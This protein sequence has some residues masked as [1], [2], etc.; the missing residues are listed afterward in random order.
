LELI[1]VRHGETEWT[2]SGRYTGITEIS[3]TTGGEREAT[4]V[5][6]ILRTLLGG[7]EPVVLASPRRRA[8]DTARLSMPAATV[9]AEPL[10]AEYDYGRYEGLTIQEI[11]ALSPGWDIWRD[12]CSNGETTQ[13]AGFRADE[14]LDLRVVPEAAP[15]VAV[16]HGH[17]SRILAAR[18]LR[19]P[20]SD[21]SMFAMSTGSVSVIKD[22]AE[23][24]CLHLWNVTGAV[25]G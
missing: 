20:A 22:S 4:A 21:A 2:L 7:R 18:A 12:G 5:G 13:A 19:R 6:P 14:F 10:L 15:V 3:L 9:I 16:T 11:T 25:A 24:R 17:F 1:I 23:G 8:T